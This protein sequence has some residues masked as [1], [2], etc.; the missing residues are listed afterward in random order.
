MPLNDV[1]LNPGINRENTPTSV[2]GTWVYAD[3]VRFR[4]G[5][6]EKIGGWQA[7][8]VIP[9]TVGVPPV[10]GS[11]WGTA[12]HLFNWLTLARYNMLGIGTSSKYYIQNG[13][14]GTLNDVTPIT[15]VTAAGGVTF[16]AT[17][18]SP[19]ITVTDAAHPAVAGDFVIFSGAVSLGGVITAA[20][21][22]QEYAITSIIGVN[23]YTITASIAANASDTGNGGIAAIAS[24]ELL[25]GPVNFIAGAG[26]GAGGWGGVTGASMTGWG[27]IVTSGT[28]VGQQ[29][30][31][32]SASNF[33]ERLIANPRGNGLYLWTPNAS[34]TIVDRMVL[35]TGGDTPIIA[36][37]VLVSDASRFVLAFGV[38]DYGETTQDPM[39]V[40]WSDQESYTDW[41]PAA[42]NQ[43]GSYRLSRGS[44]IFSA[45]QTRQEVLVWT[46]AALYSMQYQGPPFVWSTNIMGDKITIMGPNATVANDNIA[47]WMGTDKFYIY[48]GRIDTLPCSVL[49]YVFSDVNIDQR[50]LVHAGHNAAFHEVWW[51]YCSAGATEVDRYVIYNYLEQTWSVGLLSR[52]AWLGNN[53][54]IHPI[55]TSDDNLIM[56]HEIG[57][58]DNGVALP[59]YV[60]SAPMDIESGQHFQFIRRMQPDV[61][62]TGSMANAPAVTLSLIARTAPGAAYGPPNSN[63]AEANVA[64]SGQ[65][66]SGGQRHLVETFT[67]EIY[68]RLRGQQVQFKI[69]SA[70]AGVAWQLGVMRIDSR[71][72]GRK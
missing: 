56:Y 31:L 64:T 32:W 40:R 44:V 11:F 21:L 13:Y 9:A 2:E 19:I 67:N 52:T 14:G 1:K 23:S 50:F 61:S 39:L 6:P 15:S 60:E 57:T 10:V 33:G 7:D 25:N 42:T 65:D 43:A 12:R 26:W 34:P 37:Y 45:L 38:N 58:D 55:A 4:G 22:N 41:T 71:P 54:R 47:Y 59:S 27:S 62:F 66:Y 28:T 35:L 53:L 30:R 20:I 51:F 8:V 48:N 24:Y 16:A 29:P 17:N 63:P 5:T 72:D 18:G 69:E 46:D 36:N 70:G 68:P 49:R 3:K